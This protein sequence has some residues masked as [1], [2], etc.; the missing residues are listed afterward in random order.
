MQAHVHLAAGYIQFLTDAVSE[1]DDAKDLSIEDRAILRMW[2]D[3]RKLG[4]QIAKMAADMGVSERLTE[5]AENQTA[6]I[7][8]VIEA[9]AGDLGLTQS[10]RK[11]LGPALRRQL[12]KDA[13]RRRRCRGNCEVSGDE[14]MR[15]LGQAGRFRERVR[16]ARR[17]GLWPS[18][19]DHS[20]EASELRAE[21]T[22]NGLYE[23]EGD[24]WERFIA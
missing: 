19:H 18:H 5:L 1:L 4:P 17:L 6:M 12:A 14:H 7:A 15:N 23:A 13:G 24:R 10:Q 9:M 20:L 2:N 3:E 22:V 16:E 21:A 11:E 8:K